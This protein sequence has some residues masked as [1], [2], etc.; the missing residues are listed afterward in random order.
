MDRAHREVLLAAA[1]RE[2]PDAAAPRSR[3]G[4]ERTAIEQAYDSYYE[5]YE[6]YDPY[7][8]YLACELT[9]ERDGAPRWIAC[10][11]ELAA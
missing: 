2:A 1:V 6:A 4:R 3:G 8:S 10:Q 5:S 7:E 11:G 9:Y